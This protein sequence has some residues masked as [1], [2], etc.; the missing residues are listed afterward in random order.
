MITLFLDTS[1]T[2]LIVGI[3]K[4]NSPIFISNEQSENDLSSR[5]LPLIKSALEECK[6]TVDKINRILI[7]NGPGSFTGVRVGVTIAKT[8]AWSKNIDV[9]PISELEVLA[10]TKVETDYVVPLIDARRDAFYAGMY[11]KKHKNIIE[12]AYITRTALLN[13][14]KRHVSLKKVTFVSYTKINELETIL[15][16]IDLDYI[17]KKYAKKKSSNAHTVNPNYLKKVEAEEKLNDKRNK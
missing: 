8:L 9:I 12:D 4:D 7:V 11:D 5:V 13:K 3:Y 1:T 15:P 2:R 10:S 14:I 17:V 6:L 16:N